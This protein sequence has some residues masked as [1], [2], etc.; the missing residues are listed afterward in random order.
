MPNPGDLFSAF[1]GVFESVL[2]R[3]LLIVAIL[4]G[5]VYWVGHC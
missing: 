1:F 2:I 5:L 4:I 3:V